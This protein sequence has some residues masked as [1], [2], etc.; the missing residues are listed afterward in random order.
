MMN[1]V[2]RATA[3]AVIALGALSAGAAAQTSLGW[4]TLSGYAEYEHL[5]SGSDDDGY[6]NA[7]LSFSTNPDGA[8]GPALGFDA[9]LRAF[10]DGDDLYHALYAALTYSTGFGKFSAGVPRPV[11]AD[12]VR[13]APIGGVR[14]LDVELGLILG[15]VV[16][17]AYLGD[18]ENRPLGLRY[19]GRF[20][21]ATVGLSYHNIDVPG[22]NV[23]AFDIGLRYDFDGFGVLAAA[24]HV[25]IPGEGDLTNWFLGADGEFSIDTARL[26]AGLTWFGRDSSAA[27]DIDGI[28]AEVGYMPTDRIDLTGS[29][30][31]AEGDQFYG[32]EMKYRIFRG[33]YMTLG[34]VD[35][36]GFD[37][38]YDVS[39]GWQF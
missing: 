20:G 31:S 26:R 28:R 16:E 9:A 39:L 5:F 14:T 32:I 1:Q 23:E 17:T 4:G 10:H 24:E 6:F 34:A 35:G 7:D 22:T 2:A 37:T 13:F 33:A 27:D 18:D 12:M 36:D 29:L 11:V 30:I 21:G 38:V 15:S 25:N 8:S 3:T 19:D